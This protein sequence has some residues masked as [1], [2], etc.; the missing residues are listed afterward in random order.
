MA[1]TDASPDIPEPPTA[2][3]TEANGGYI[4]DKP[5]TAH[6][7]LS[8]D[9]G[10]D[11]G[12]ASSLDDDTR[13]TQAFASGLA[14]GIKPPPP[15]C[16]VVVDRGLS[17]AEVWTP[18]P[19]NRRRPADHRLHDGSGHRRG[20]QAIRRRLFLWRRRRDPRSFVGVLVSGRRSR[21]LGG[22]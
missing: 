2:W 10:T 21:W 11:T 4:D 17:R 7:A 13:Q 15:H 16:A 1:D 14:T 8:S 5:V 3:D 20:H 6:V 9:T 18:A 19:W 22:P 12:S